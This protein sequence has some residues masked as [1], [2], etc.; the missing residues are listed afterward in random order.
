MGF[1]IERI[2]NKSM[3]PEGNYVVIEGIEYQIYELTISASGNVCMKIW[4]PVRKEH[5][6]KTLCKLE[7][8]VNATMPG[9]G[10]KEY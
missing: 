10:F 9:V 6:V 5:Q 3:K 4:D 1:V 2:T 7:E 8:L